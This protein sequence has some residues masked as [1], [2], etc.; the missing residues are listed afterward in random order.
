MVDCWIVRTATGF[1]PMD[2]AELPKGWKIGDRLM[3]TIRKPRNSRLHRK[4]FVLLDVIWPHTEYP[5]KEI[6]RKAMTIGAGFVDE[7]VN[8]MT[9]EVSWCARSWK[10]DSMDDAEFSELY[11]RLIDVAL[12]II[13]QSTRDDWMTAVEEVARF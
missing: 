8:P 12:K 4:A 10:F 3:A 9:G 7:I 6:L 2:T 1:A 13:P 11:S 5:N